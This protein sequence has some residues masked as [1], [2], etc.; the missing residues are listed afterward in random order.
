MAHYFETLKELG[1]YA[2]NHRF[3]VDPGKSIF[4]FSATG[5]QG[6]KYFEQQPALRRV[7]SFIARQVASV[8]LNLYSWDDKG[9]RARLYPAQHPAASFLEFPANQKHAPGTTA[10]MLKE[11]LLTDALIHDKFCAAFEYDE[12][13]GLPTSMMRLPASRVKFHGAAGAVS[14]ATYHREDG[15]RI[16]LNLDYLFFKIGYTPHTGANGVP[17]I[18]TLRE[19]LDGNTAALEYRSKILTEAVRAPGVLT[20]PGVLDDKAYE[21]LRSSWR[22]HAASG[23]KAGEE[24]ILEDGVKYEQ[25]KP[26]TGDD[27]LDLDGRKLTDEE[28]AT[29]YWVYPELLGLREGTNSNMQALKQAL[30]SICLGPYVEDWQQSWN[31]MLRTQFRTQAKY[32]EADVSKKLEG[33]FKEESEIMSRAVGGPFMSV[34]EA[35]RKRNMPSAGKEYDQIIVPKNVTQGGQA[36]PM[37]GE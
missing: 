33:D 16:E 15:E 27:V 20:H 35:R 2:R 9:D 25:L 29:M 30:W 32:I 18:N 26:L 31:L 8:N 36:S 37:S 6:A 19:L 3:V 23:G 11:Q 5:E 21:R 10:M 34:N 12:R 22:E 28:V 24:P 14:G 4:D 17:Q 1:T 7:V 13:T